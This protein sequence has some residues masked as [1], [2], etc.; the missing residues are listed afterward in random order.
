MPNAIGVANVN[1][2]RQ[3]FLAYCILNF[4]L[5]DHLLASGLSLFDNRQWVSGQLVRSDV[6]GQVAK[7]DDFEV[8]RLQV[9]HVLL[10]TFWTR[11]DPR[12]LVIGHAM[13]LHH[14]DPAGARLVH[15]ALE[16]VERPVRPR[17]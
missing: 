2:R 16:I 1:S 14:S 15:A 13:K 4:S 3:W 11:V 10:E 7:C 17:I 5:D 8:V 6:A 12:M 9:T